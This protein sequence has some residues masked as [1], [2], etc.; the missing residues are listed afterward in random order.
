M[1]GYLRM[2]K[3]EELDEVPPLAIDSE[4]KDFDYDDMPSLCSHSDS[5][6]SSEFKGNDPIPILSV[7]PD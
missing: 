7:H 3:A 6:S 4:S 1:M 5:D 2:M